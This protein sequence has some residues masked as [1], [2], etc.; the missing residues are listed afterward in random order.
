MYQQ[1]MTRY[2]Y[3]C[4]ILDIIISNRTWDLRLFL[5]L[6]SFSLVSMYSIIFIVI[7][8]CLYQ[9]KQLQGAAQCKRPFFS[10]P[11]CIFHIHLALRHVGSSLILR[12]ARLCTCKH[13]NSCPSSFLSYLSK[14]ACQFMQVGPQPHYVRLYLS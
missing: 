6:V 11:M 9:D 14:W 2:P 13:K 5:L 12:I 10:L 3:T 1:K 4:N 8:F 7:F